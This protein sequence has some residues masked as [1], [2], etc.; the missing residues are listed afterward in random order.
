MFKTILY[1]TVIFCCIGMYAQDQ[2][3]TEIKVI[4]R[5]QKDRVLLR[6][7]PNSPADWQLL[8]KYGYAIERYTISRDQKTLSSAEKRSITPNPIVPEPLQNWESEIQT[9]DEAAIIAQALYGKDFVVTGGDQLETVVNQSESLRQRYSFALFAADQ[10]FDIAIK[11]GLGFIDTKAKANEK[12]LYRIVP[13]VPQDKLKIKQGSVFVGIIDYEP[14]P[15]PIDFIGVF[16]DN[17]VVL[18]WDSHTLS[19]TY[20]SYHIEKS[21]NGKTFYSVNKKPFTTLDK[22]TNGRKPTR[23]Q[24]IDSITNDVSYRYRIKGVTAFGEIG[25]ES[26][27]VSGTGA[28]SL[29]STPQLLTK[30]IKEDKIVIF[31]WDFPEAANADILRFELNKSVTE[32]GPYDVVKSIGPLERSIEYADL[33]P[34]NYFTITAV[35]VLGDKQTSFPMLVQP[36]DT[37]PPTKPVQLSGTIDTLGIVRLQWAENKEKDILGYRVYVANSPDEEFSL[38]SASTV[39]KT[40]FVDTISMKM[41]NAKV[42]YKITAEDQ[43]FN[44]SEFSEVLELTKPDKIPPTTPVFKKYEI[45]GKKIALEW[46][47]SSSDDVA[48]YRIYRKA[49]TERQWVLIH[50]ANKDEVRYTDK[51]IADGNAYEYTLLAIDEA[52]LESK[53]SP[54]ISVYIKRISSKPKVKGFYAQVNSQN[55]TVQL[56]WRYKEKNV[57][58]YEL[59]KGI[60]GQKIRLLRILPAET[61][62]FKDEK[63]TINST[64]QYAIRAVFTDGNVSE[65]SL[66]TIKY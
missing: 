22:A 37:I 9:N 54:P 53:P 60:Q 39:P 42:Y 58:E 21:I 14:L 64:Y 27:I 20:T 3:N 57:S 25:P 7:A 4:A 19:D 43:R 65:S 31:H 38:L 63:I 44:A 28:S 34:T 13:N 41:L 56:S 36:K 32:S 62:F 6:W 48:L 55:E 50:E 49:H 11:A 26:T 8:N 16:N 46:S 15:K 40:S 45:L 33:D 66:L 29:K 12:Y 10:N 35:G 59:Y 2:S 51:K 52:G 61:S 47:P 23:I 30:H 17:H 18:S 1:I 5:A 24:F